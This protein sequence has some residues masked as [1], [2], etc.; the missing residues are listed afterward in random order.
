MSIYRA[1]CGGD[2]SPSESLGG[3][4]E[5][6]LPSLSR[7]LTFREG[8]AGREGRWPKHEELTASPGTASLGIETRE[9]LPVGGSRGTGWHTLSPPTGGSP[10][11]QCLQTIW[12]MTGPRWVSGAQG[13]TEYITHVTRS[14]TLGDK[15]RA[16]AVCQM[17]TV[18]CDPT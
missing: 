12:R 9:G 1:A 14:L 15:W 4:S 7:T 18:C 3:I 16:A 13:C 11:Q 8:Y 17:S 2:L 6:V 5:V 10:N